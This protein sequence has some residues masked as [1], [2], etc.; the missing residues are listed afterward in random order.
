MAQFLRKTPQTQF[1]RSNLMLGFF[2]NLLRKPLS[3]AADRIYSRFG[4][5]EEGPDQP[6]AVQPSAV[7]APSRMQPLPAKAAGNANGHGNGNGR[8]VEVPLQSVLNN[9]PLELQPKVRVTDVGDMT[10]SIPLEKV[11][12][13]LSRGAVKISF[14]ELRQAVPEVFTTENDRDRVLVSLPLSEILPRLNPALITR[15]RVQRQVQVPAEVASP[16]DGQ[17]Q[18]L[19]FSIGPGKGN[20]PATPAPAARQA[21]VAPVPTHSP[22]RS[23]LTS[24]PKPAV[25]TLNSP[26]APTRVNLKPKPAPGLARPGFVPPSKAPPAPVALKAT[27]PAPVP[28]PPAPEPE[29]VEPAVP[30]TPIAQAPSPIPFSP[31]AAP[32]P[33][34][35]VAPHPESARPQALRKAP[36]PKPAV[37]PVHAAP[38]PQPAAPTAPGEVLVLPLTSLADNWPEVIRKEIVDMNLV[39][40]RVGLPVHAVEQALKQGK[41]AFTWKILRSWIKPTVLPA[42]SAHDNVLLELPLK[43]VAPQFLALQKKTA[44]PQQKV[45]IDDE[46]PNL[47]FGFP[48][49][50]TGV[51]VAQATASPS[52]TNFYVWDDASDRAKV[53]ETDFKRGP[54]PGTRFVSK[55]ATP[56]EVVSRAA[57]LDGVAGVLIA[58]P[59][60]LMVAN[61]LP[62]D[63]NA[64]TIAAFLPQIF[65][66]VSQCTKELRM[67]E[68]NNLNFTVGNIPWKIFR[69]NAIFFAA[70][71]RAGEPL[72]TAQLA[73]LAAEL[74]HK[75]K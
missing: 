65:G 69:V 9:L 29:P 73:A 56:N 72:P 38:V 4:P 5:A 58:L 75:P 34:R 66:K 63:A 17:G 27:P 21:S 49:P 26:A 55:Y 6:E 42:V 16:F 70:F 62:T 71:G 35:P 51:P 28:A 25:P 47:F 57:A 40:A 68:L 18:G 3:A 11:L 43:I 61:R 48:Q 2:K 20:V 67:G 10:I 64:D 1:N 8:G 60:G 32:H 14:G 41:I 53:D 36:E 31:K 33:I 50:E 22:S 52:D 74:D 44:K 30:E 59:D 12:A 24:A 23:T 19:V 54:G 45:A 13:Q 39:D 37:S 46:I 7:S 15:R